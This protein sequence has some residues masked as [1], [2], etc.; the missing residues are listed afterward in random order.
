MNISKTQVLRFCVQYFHFP[1]A[2]TPKLSIIRGDPNGPKNSR[3]SAAA[4]SAVI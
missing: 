3:T 4:P 1:Q 2:E